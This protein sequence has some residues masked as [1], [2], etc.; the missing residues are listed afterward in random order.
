MGKKNSGGAYIQRIFLI[1]FFDNKRTYEERYLSITRSLDY[2]VKKSK[3]IKLITNADLITI[4]EEYLK[5]RIKN[6]LPLDK[7]TSEQDITI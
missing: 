1:K 2:Y 7:E 4:K 6:K 5:F 3:D